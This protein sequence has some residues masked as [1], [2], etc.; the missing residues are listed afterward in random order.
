MS[1]ISATNSTLEM[2][3]IRQPG[4]NVPLGK[5]DRRVRRTRETLHRA[6]IS[7]ILEKGYEAV[8]V[9]D[10]VERA[11]VGR[12]T[13]YAHYLGKEDLL[14]AEMNDLRAL[15][16]ARQRESLARQGDVAERA[17]GFSLA[18]F[19]HAQGYRDIYRALIGERGATIMVSRIRALLAE[20]V[21]RDLADLLPTAV[22][23]DVPASALVQ[24][25]VGALM[26][27]LIWWVERETKFTPA[28][29]DALFRRL[30]IP[31]IEA[32][33]IGSTPAWRSP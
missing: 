22:A 17:L 21:Q 7:L 8:T 30:T 15:L 24:F 23:N 32:S 28:Q 16:A 33:V 2:S 4:E 20:L 6:M 13:F 19:E 31:A 26:S 11:N 12:S 18:L 5:K 10:V 29:V 14:T 1:D 9:A 27:I 3:K 25:T